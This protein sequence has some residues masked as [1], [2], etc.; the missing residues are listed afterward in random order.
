MEQNTVSI[1][2]LRKRS[3][4]NLER[5]RKATSFNV[6][7]WKRTRLERSLGKRLAKGTLLDDDKHQEHA[8]L[9][10]RRFQR[11]WGYLTKDE[12]AKNLRFLTILDRLVE[13]D[14]EAMV[15]AGEH[16]L[17]WLKHVLNSELRNIGVIGCV[18]MEVVNLS[19]S[20]KKALE[21]SQNTHALHGS[22]AKSS[23]PT[24]DDNEHRKLNVLRK[25]RHQVAPGSFFHPTDNT[26]SWVLIHF[27]GLVHLNET[28]DGIDALHDRVAK[29]LRRHW[30][31]PYAVELKKTF[32][33]QPARTK[34]AA[35]ADYITK[36]GNERLRYE[37]QFGRGMSEVDV[38]ERAMW[39]Q[40]YRGI[41]AVD[42]IESSMEDSVGLT[43]GEVE[44]LGKAIYRLMKRN[45]RGDGYVLQMGRFA[46]QTRQYSR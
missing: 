23:L 30:K 26:K 3:A 18:E 31:L 27:H 13:V 12:A 42:G 46:S 28:G 39:K 11:Q 17:D 10:F 44:A 4:K 24:L 21:S 9:M 22:G 32:E 19:H 7:V 15:G 45:H 36:C 5:I 29:K 20:E 40:G 25:M 34:F 38:T 33:N 35:I 41:D 43:V 14:V 2:D 37:T 1:Q 6:G 16:L 8:Q